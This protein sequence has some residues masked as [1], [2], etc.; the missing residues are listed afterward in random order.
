MIIV[1]DNAEFILDPQGMSAREIYAVVDELT[2]F[3]NICLCI[4][5]RISTI[6]PGCETLEIPALTMEAAR[7]TFYGICKRG[8]QSDPINDILE[9]LDFHPLSVTLLATVALHNRWDANRLTRE[10]KRQ[11]TGVLRA[12]HSGSLAATIE[13]SLASPMFRELGPDARELLGVIAFFPRGVNEENI[14]WLFPAISQST[15]DTFSI[16]SLTYWSDGFITM[17]A[18]LRDHLRPKDP[19]SSP[20]LCTAKEI[21]FSRLSVG[22]GPGEPSFTDGQWVTSED[23]NVEHLLDVLTSADP[24]SRSAW[25][26]CGEFMVHLYWHKPRLIVLG[27]KI[28]ALPDDHPLKA[29]CLNHLSSLFKS[30]GNPAKS[31]QLLTQALEVGRMRGDS[32]QVALTLS[33]LSDAN[34]LLGFTKEGTQQTKEASEIFEKLGDTANQA[35]CL[36]NLARLLASDNQL[37]AAE[38][39]ASR[40]MD[41]LPGE[42][43]QFRV[44]NGHRVLGRIYCSKRKTEKA[45]HHYEVALGIVSSLN[46]HTALSWVHYALAELFLAE[47][48]FDDAQVHI[49]RAK[50]HAVDNVYGLGRATELQA[51]LWYKRCMFEEAKLEASRAAEIYEKLKV[52]KGVENCRNLFRKIDRS[53]L[54]GAGERSQRMTLAAR[55]NVPLQGQETE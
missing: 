24:N 6:P 45:I 52:E 9:Q 7:E 30:A 35:E 22:L 28:E 53:D 48:R 8:E 44:C 26:A 29:H 4:T 23:V 1:L 54:G 12:Q 5:S 42:G 49:E 33:S 40:A 3:S 14:S 55:I 47:G 37:D 13:L 34:R 2:R 41:L 27:P 18:P 25:D 17:L 21:Y 46:W 16:L 11:R 50:S 19:M 32:H 10:W 36:I 39:A 15:F 38:E 20:L 51:K 31:K 43:E